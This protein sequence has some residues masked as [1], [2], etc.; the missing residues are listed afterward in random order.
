MCQFRLDGSPEFE[1]GRG[2]GV[3]QLQTEHRG[4]VFL[5]RGSRGTHAFQQH[6]KRWRVSVVGGHSLIPSSKPVSQCP[7]HRV[8]LI[9]YSPQFELLNKCCVTTTQGVTQVCAGADGWCLLSA[10]RRR[11]RPSTMQT[12]KMLTRCASTSQRL[13]QANAG[14]GPRAAVTSSGGDHQQRGQQ[15]R[16]ALA[17]AAAAIAA[18]R[19]R[20]MQQQ[21]KRCQWQQ[22]AVDVES[23]C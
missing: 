6:S 11:L 20:Q 18:S 12:V 19:K 10:G 15:Q 8:H 22:A 2:A 3:G 7:P 1:E 17:A 14:A 21:Q 5:G 9:A 13:L 23:G 4:S 16:L